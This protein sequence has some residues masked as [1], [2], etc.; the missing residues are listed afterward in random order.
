VLSDSPHTGAE[1]FKEETLNNDP[2]AIDVEVTEVPFSD[3][4]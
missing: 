3:I 4:A 1:E 2:H